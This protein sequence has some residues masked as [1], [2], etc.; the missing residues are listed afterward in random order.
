MEINALNNSVCCAIHCV[1]TSFHGN[2]L[3]TFHI[4]YYDGV[5]VRFTKV[6]SSYDDLINYL[7]DDCGC[8]IVTFIKI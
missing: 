7:V 6:F 4:K 2:L 5:S 8:D 1:C 3:C